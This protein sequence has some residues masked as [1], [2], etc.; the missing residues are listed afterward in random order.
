MLAVH[1]LHAVCQ[2][3][4]SKDVCLLAVLVADQCDVCGS[5]GIVLDTDYCS[6]DAVL[7]SLEVN[8]SVFSSGSA[9]AVSD[10]NLALIVTA[11]VL[12]Q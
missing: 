10:R 2:A 4:G 5:V 8:D 12:C 7:I 1:N 3:F 11:G 9:S 6:G